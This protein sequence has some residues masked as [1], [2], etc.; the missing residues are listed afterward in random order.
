MSKTKSELTER[1]RDLYEAMSDISED[2]YC[3][4]WLFN[5]EHTLW[6][7]VHSSERPFRWGLSLVEARDLDHL[8]MLSDEIGG[9]IAW[10]ENMDPMLSGPV[11]VPTGEWMR[12]HNERLK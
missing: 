1:Q 9:W 11:F 10:Q 7:A 6:D 5:T 3:A 4:G 8:R 2:C 12:R